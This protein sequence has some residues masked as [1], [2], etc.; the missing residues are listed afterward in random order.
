MVLPACSRVIR[1]VAYGSDPR[2]RVGVYAP[3]AGGGALVIFMI[4]GGWACGEKTMC[5]VVEHTAARWM[6]RGFLLVSIDY[7]MAPDI[8]RLEQAADVARALAA[9]QRQAAPRAATA[10]ASS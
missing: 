1:D 2:Q 6:P 8:G 3:A 9:A 10:G 7:R 4:H 5:T